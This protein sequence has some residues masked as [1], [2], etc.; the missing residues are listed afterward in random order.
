MG[1]KS[2]TSLLLFSKFWNW[3]RVRIGTIWGQTGSLI[4]PGERCLGSANYSLIYMRLLWMVLQGDRNMVTLNGQQPNPMPKSSGCP[5]VSYI[6]KSFHSFFS[7]VG[8][9]FKL[10]W[11][12]FSIFFTLYFHFSHC[13]WVLRGYFSMFFPR[14]FYFHF[15]HCA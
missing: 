5:L 9:I 1:G 6:L 13:C 15:S 10:L 7:F 3:G 8:D 11:C 4:K 14:L 2:H 12:L